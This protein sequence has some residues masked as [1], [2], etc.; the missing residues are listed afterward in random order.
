MLGAEGMS[1]AQ[2]QQEERV[3]EGRN[4]PIKPEE[5]IRIYQLTCD[6]ILN[7]LEEI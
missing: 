3:C 7:S 4:S 5:V 2:C 6:I 1:I